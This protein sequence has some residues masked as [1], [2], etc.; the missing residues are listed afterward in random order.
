M[1]Q[2]DERPQFNPKHRIA[3]AIILVSLAVIFVPMLLDES[4]PPAENPTLAQIPARDA[5]A[6]ETKVVVM[7]VPAPEPAKTQTAIAD[8]A[9]EQSAPHS[10]LAVLEKTETPKVVEAKAAPA[11]EKKND[12]SAA[13]PKPVVAKANEIADKLSKGWVVQVGTFANTENAG[14]LR[15]KLK[16]HGFAV[17]AESVAFQ[18]GKAIRLRVG[19]FP[20][21]SA[22][23]KAQAQLQKELNIQG[24]VLAYP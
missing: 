8:A 13:K 15:E 17:N 6:S 3:G 21:K 20:D 5:P 14:R 1:A 2:D 19:P 4:K 7:P 22:A 23:A 12:T 18:G 9:P 11:V 24:L 10:P 16:N